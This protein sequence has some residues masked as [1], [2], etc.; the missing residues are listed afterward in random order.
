MPQRNAVYACIPSP[1]DGMYQTTG[2]GGNP[3]LT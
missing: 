1:K 3:W 2:G